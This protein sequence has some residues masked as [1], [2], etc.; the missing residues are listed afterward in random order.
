MQ[1]PPTG[2]RPGNLLLQAVVFAIVLGLLQWP[3]ALGAWQRWIGLG[4]GLQLSAGLWLTA[5]IG[6]WIPIGLYAALDRWRAPQALTRFKIQAVRARPGE[7]SARAALALGLLNTL[8]VLPLCVLGV[9]GL[10]QLRGWAP[11]AAL[12]RL[13]WVVLNLGLLS[14]IADLSFYLGHRLLHRPW[15]MRNV[16]E[17]HHRFLA[18]T[19]LASQYQHPLEFALT[20]VG[21]LALGIVVLAPDALSIV[22]FVLL[23][24]Y[25]VVATHSGYNLP[26][27][28]FAGY[29][30]LHHEKTRGNFGVTA[31]WDGI[32]GTRLARR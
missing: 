13:P 17:L 30:D 1:A 5:L 29:H 20:G 8:L 4:D 9:Y 12:P 2:P 14:A 32:F 26:F 11:S 28:P 23:G 3:P 15:W 27:A 31:L 6:T 18:P 19:G 7:P 21:P 22:L 25:N 24:S 10:L 16:H